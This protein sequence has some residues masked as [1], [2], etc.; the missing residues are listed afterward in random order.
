MEF[1]C[2]TRENINYKL[3]K[4][5]NRCLHSSSQYKKDFCKSTAQPELRLY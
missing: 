2:T 5:H 4:R 1:D 3:I